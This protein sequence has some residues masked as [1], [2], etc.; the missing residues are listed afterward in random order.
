MGS[1]QA[2]RPRI[3][4]IDDD[5]P[6]ASSVRQAVPDWDVIACYNGVHGIARV[7]EEHDRLDLVVLDVVMPHDGIYTCVQIRGQ[8][9]NLRVMPYTA[10][11]E[12][13]GT[14]A[15]LG[16]LPPLLKPASPGDLAAA[17]HR[18][19]GLPVPPMRELPVWRYLENRA[20]ESE[21]EFLQDRRTFQVATLASS[22]GLQ[23]ALCSDVTAAGGAVRLQSTSQAQLRNALTQTRV[24]V[25]VADNYCADDAIELC[26][27]LGLPLLLIA[28]TP[29]ESYGLVRRMEQNEVFGGV[30]VNPAEPWSIANAF[31][32]LA[33]LTVYRDPRMK[34]AL[35]KFSGAE[36]PIAE[37]MAMGDSNDAI[38]AERGLAKQ[39]VRLYRSNIYVKTGMS[40]SSG[41]IDQFRKWLNDRML[42]VRH[43]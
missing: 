13:L 11:T 4:V 34:Y 3:L 17:L 7:R 21:R 42:N 5:A 1:Q 10:A 9:P 43:V 23:T 32:E 20:S 33:P 37:L 24:S 40:E 6:I 8:Y 35:S 14:L 27:L 31:A 25:V 2:A 28:F 26:R 19:L 38:A 22:S 36:Q 29:W 15:D 41:D 16:C 12:H 18:S 30:V 39:T